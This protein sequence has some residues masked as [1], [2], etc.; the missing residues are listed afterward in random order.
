MVCRKTIQGG[1]RKKDKT[2]IE[3]VTVLTNHHQPFNERQTSLLSLIEPNLPVNNSPTLISSPFHCQERERRKKEK[4]N[5][6]FENL[7]EF[8]TDEPPLTIVN[9]SIRS[10]PRTMNLIYSDT[11]ERI[12]EPTLEGEEGES[13]VD[14][15]GREGA[16]Q[17]TR[18]GAEGEGENTYKTERIH[19]IKE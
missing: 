13:R 2:H 4:E 8:R 19:Q 10:M 17:R 12:W 9:S 5:S 11:E 18:K 16:Q 6:L 15:T 1:K 7:F 3:D 14:Q